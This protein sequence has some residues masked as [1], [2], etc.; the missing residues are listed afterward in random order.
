ML[1][2]GTALCERTR[3][4]PL[5]QPPDGLSHRH[6]SGGLSGL[7]SPLSAP[8]VPGGSGTDATRR[9]VTEGLAQGGPGLAAG[10]KGAGACLMRSRLLLIASCIQ[11]ERRGCLFSKIQT[12]PDALRWFLQCPQEL[13]A[14]PSGFVSRGA[15]G[16]QGPSFISCPRHWAREGSPCSS[17]EAGLIARPSRA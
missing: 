5:P 8:W 16:R 10:T 3:P 6:R 7:R 17:R 12:F 2:E 11:E 13:Q 4:S 14:L 9:A 1:G 15:G